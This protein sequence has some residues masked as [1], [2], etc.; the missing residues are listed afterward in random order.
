MAPGANQLVVGGDSCD[1]KLEGNQGVYNA[2][3]AIL[4]GASGHP[5]A[6]VASNSWETGSE[7]QPLSQT[8]L[9]HAYLVRA[10]AEGVGM[11]FSAGDGSGVLEPSVD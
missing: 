9:V 4:D 7:S 5:L 10:A 1:Q 6:S 11:Y 8:N 3:I 2:D